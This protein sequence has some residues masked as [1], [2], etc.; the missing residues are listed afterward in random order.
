MD[1]HA[2]LISAIRF[3]SPH[4]YEWIAELYNNKYV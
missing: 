1:I 3:I 2:G 4:K